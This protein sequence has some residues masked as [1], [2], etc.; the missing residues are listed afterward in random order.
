MVKK[1]L[2]LLDRFFHLLKGPVRISP[3]IEPASETWRRKTINKNQR[4]SNFAKIDQL[5][6]T[7]VRREDDFRSAKVLIELNYLLAF[8]SPYTR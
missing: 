7:I 5:E 2:R 8:R 1:R 4:S 6:E 3:G